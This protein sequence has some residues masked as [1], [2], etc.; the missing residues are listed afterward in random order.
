MQVICIENQMCDL[1]IR[2]WGA[3]RVENDMINERLMR[4][5]EATRKYLTRHLWGCTGCSTSHLGWIVDLMGKP[6]R[7]CSGGGINFRWVNP[8]E[9]DIEY[10]R[11]CLKYRREIID[12][13][14]MKK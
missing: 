2:V 3:A 11:L 12:E 13:L 14:K 8:V 10:I 5:D 4:E 1:V 7:V 9:A 6:R